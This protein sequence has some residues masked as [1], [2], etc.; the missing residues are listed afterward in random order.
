MKI[1]AA[2][3]R[4]TRATA[5][6]MVLAGCASESRPPVPGLPQQAGG[7]SAAPSTAAPRD[8]SRQGIELTALPGW[9][10]DDLAGLGS[11]LGRQ[12]QA[13][14]AP[15]RW[16]ELCGGVIPSD[17]A[18]LRGWLEKNFRAWPLA[19]ADGST[20]GLIT[21][22]YEPVL[23]GS[24]SR[25][26]PG[27]TPVYAVPDPGDRSRTLSR[28]E[29][30]VT[31]LPMAQVLLWLDDPVDAF[32]LHVQ[33]SGRVRLRDGALVR[34]GFAGHNGQG[35]VAIGRVLVERG[36]LR[37]EEADMAGIRRWLRERLASDPASARAVMRANP[38]YIFF[39]KLAHLPDEA[40]PPGSI[41]VALTP[42]RSIAT[43]PNAVPPGSVMFLAT[44]LP[45]AG[46][47][48]ETPFARVV[49]NQ[50]TGAAIVG[51]VRADLFTG[52]GSAAGELAGRMRQRGQLW[53]LWPANS[54][55]P[56]WRNAR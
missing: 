31:G 27:Q 34:I 48:P 51:Q 53:L 37:L 18:S 32:F 26:S 22:Y 13:S 1:L 28:G 4:F 55:P 49:V 10:G 11:A 44:S 39:R 2:A 46:D 6:V 29:I 9:A 56:T 42:R 14:A 40:G 30:E 17:G 16:P 25:E 52:T 12:C 20:D 38:R 45:A 21:G 33:G 50:D 35:Y 15:G 3:K 36:E 7:S 47:G 24:L 8:L 23:T 54:T 41:G 5:L 19:G 43:D